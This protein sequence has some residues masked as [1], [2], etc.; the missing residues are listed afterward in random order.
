MLVLSREVGKAIVVGETR[1]LVLAFEPKARA[2]SGTGG[3]VTLSIRSAD[4]VWL[5][6]PIDGILPMILWWWIHFLLTERRQYA[7]KKAP[8][9]SP[10]NLTDILSKRTGRSPRRNFLMYFLWMRMKRFR[11]N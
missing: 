7:K 4:E 9:L 3:T 11:M 10:I 1:I 2:T 6:A 5:R 8:A